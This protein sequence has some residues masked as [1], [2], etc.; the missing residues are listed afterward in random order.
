ME[1]LKKI[2]ELIESMSIDS[3]KVYKGN[4]S[5]SIRARQNAQEVKSLIGEFRKEI[6]AE[7][8]LHDEVRNNIKKQKKLSTD[9]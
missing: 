6:L 9:V 8:K 7:I 1:S 5:A 2:K 3:Q 4:H